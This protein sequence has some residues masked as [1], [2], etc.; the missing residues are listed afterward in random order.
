MT[1]VVGVVAAVWLL[2]PAP[3]PAQGPTAAAPGG[4]PAATGVIEGEKLFATL[5]GWCHQNGGR[6]VGKGPKL[7][8]LEQ[9]DQYIVNRI[10]NGKQGQMPAFGGVFNEEQIRAIVA[11]IRALK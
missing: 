11:Y 6:S 3:A 7:A 1:A 10:K 9:P 5:C 2:G 8:G 4:G